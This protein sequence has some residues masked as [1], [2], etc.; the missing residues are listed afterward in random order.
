MRHQVSGHQ[1]SVV[2][3]SEHRLLPGAPAQGGGTSGTDIRWDLT[4]PLLPPT[5]QSWWMVWGGSCH[6]S[7]QVHAYVID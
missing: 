4:V 2:T 5:Q 6:L 3:A 7:C 1:L